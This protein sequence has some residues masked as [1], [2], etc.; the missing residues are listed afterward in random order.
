MNNMKP[1]QVVGLTV[2]LA[3]FASCESTDMADNRKQT[4]SQEAKHI[5]AEQRQRQESAETTEA[6]RNLWNAQHDILTR[7]G[8]AAAKDY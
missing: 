2:G 6:Q 4:G 1:L 5:A 8:N 7:D 3:L